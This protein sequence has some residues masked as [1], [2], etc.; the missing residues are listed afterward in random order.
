MSKKEFKTKNNNT[1]KAEA[2]DEKSDDKKP[3]NLN[4]YKS[5]RKE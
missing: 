5:K 3:K 4:T 2:K 1:S